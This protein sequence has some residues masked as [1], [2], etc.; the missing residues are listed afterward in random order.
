[1]ETVLTLA[2]ATLEVQI[3]NRVNKKQTIKK[4][5][6]HEVLVL[7]TGEVK[8]VNRSETRKDNIH[9]LRM[10][11]KKLR[12]LINAN[13]VGNKN[14]LFLTLTYS[15]N[16]TDVRRLY[17]D[18]RKFIQRLRYKYKDVSSLEYIAVVEP[19]ERGAW[20]YHILVK[21][22]DVDFMYIPHSELENLWGHGFVSVQDITSVDNIGAYLS[23]YLSNTDNIKGGRLYLY[24]VGM[25]IYRCSRGIV[26]PK[27]IVE[28]PL[29]VDA[30][31]ANSPVR[32]EGTYEYDNKGYKVH[33]TYKQ[34]NLFD[35]GVDKCQI[36]DYNWDKL[37]EY[38]LEKW[39]D[40]WVVGDDQGMIMR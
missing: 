2:G 32:F 36:L 16:M 20:H 15:E 19:Q 37:K 12:Y 30:V 35:L 25:K 40:K 3:L 34:Y 24:P 26:K 33:V 14:E 17:D 22:P 18:G 29:V 5:N 9:S 21:F 13:F 27:R 10:T 38:L 31:L 6:D 8:T 11:L 23:A 28:N 39:G 1:M 7:S 4:L